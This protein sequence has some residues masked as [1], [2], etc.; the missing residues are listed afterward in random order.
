[1]KIPLEKESGNPLQDSGKS[2]EQRSLE[3]YSPWGRKRVRC[4]VA[5]ESNNN[6]DYYIFLPLKIP[7]LLFTAHTSLE[8]HQEEESS[9]L[10][11]YYL[12]GIE[13]RSLYTLRK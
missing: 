5:T 7:F 13:P 6:W 8:S 3:G 2:H 1:M 12:L 9:F 10:R 11:S 4:S